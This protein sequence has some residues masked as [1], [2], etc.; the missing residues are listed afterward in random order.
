MKKQGY[1]F[2]TKEQNKPET[3]LNEIKIS[4]LLEELK[5][6]VIKLFTEVRRPMHEKKK[7]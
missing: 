7:R 2:Q 5:L 6:T 4:D 1:L 3:Q